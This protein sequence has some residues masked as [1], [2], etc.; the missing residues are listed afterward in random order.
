MGTLSVPGD[1][2]LN[3]FFAL[4]VVALPLVLLLLVVLHLGALHEVGSNNPDGVDVKH[5]PKGNRWNPNAP[6]DGIPFHPYYTLK[7]LVGVGVFLVVCAIIIFFEPTVG[8]FF[9][10]HDNSIPANDLVTPATIKPVWYFSPFYAILRMIPSKGFGVLAMLASIVVLFLVPWLDRGKVKSVRYRGLA[11]KIALT[12]FTIVFLLLCAIGADLTQ[13]W[14]MGLFGAS[15]ATAVS[16][17]LVFGRTLVV[18]YFAFFIFLWAYTF[19]GW[20]KTKPVPERVTTH[21]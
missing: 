11:Y 2:T 20:E 19:F 21:A 9:I 13:G 12:L 16:A 14:I 1:P 18:L 10:E 8:G 3:R 15:S 7:D 5:G 17:E 4:H 6:V